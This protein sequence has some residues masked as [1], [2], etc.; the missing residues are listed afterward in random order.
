MFRRTSWSYF[1]LAGS[2]FAV[3]PRLLE[4]CYR[5]TRVS[6]VVEVMTRGLLFVSRRWAVGLVFFVFFGPFVFGLI[7]IGP[8]YGFYGFCLFNKIQ[9]EKKK[10]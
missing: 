6:L 5:V 2:F 1:V 9:M 10:K 3:G 8:L 4:V 7:G